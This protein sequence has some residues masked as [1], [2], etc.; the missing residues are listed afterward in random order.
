MEADK[1]SDKP[2]THIVSGILV[3]WCVGYLVIGKSSDP[4]SL[5]DSEGSR[6]I[7]CSLET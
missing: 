5:G 3:L 4:E 2:G 1:Q 7:T 6:G